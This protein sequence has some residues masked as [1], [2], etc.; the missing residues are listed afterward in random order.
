MVILNCRTWFFFNL[1]NLLLSFIKVLK[2]QKW[3]IT[4]ELSLSLKAGT[5]ES[6]VIQIPW[7]QIYTGSVNLLIESPHLIFELNVLNP[8]D[9]NSKTTDSFAHD[10]KMVCYDH[11]IN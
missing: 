8:L 1:D 10:F 3:K 4:Q 6:L 9:E 5:I 11:L 2:Q 7:T